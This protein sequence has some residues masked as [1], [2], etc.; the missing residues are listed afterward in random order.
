MLPS[1]AWE[2]S[3]Y[4]FAIAGVLLSRGCCGVSWRV[5]CRVLDSEKPEV[6]QK[7]FFAIAGEEYLVLQAEASS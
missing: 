7:S 1:W 6:I 5:A 4:P 3:P 2:T